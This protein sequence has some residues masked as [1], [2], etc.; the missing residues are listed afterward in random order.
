[1]NNNWKSS[2]WKKYPIRQQPN[3]PNNTELQKVLEE[4]K[5][6]PSLVFAGEI[7]NLTESLKNLEKNNSF[8]IQAG[9]CAESF[10]NCN[11][12][13]IHNYL[14]VILQMAKIIQN[15][16][17]KNIIKIGRIAG[18][19]SKPRSVDFETVA[20][21]VYEVYRGDNVNGVE[22]DQNIRKPN[23]TN[24]IKGY[25]YSAATLNL[26]RAFT[27]GGY[28][29][30]KYN[31]DWIKHPFEMEANQFLSD[32][33]LSSSR[34]SS[35][36]SN[37]YNDFFISHEALILDYEQAFTREDSIFGDFF[38][39]SAHTL[40]IGDR[41]RF[42]NSAHIEYVKG[43]NN[44]IGIKIGPNYDLND[45]ISILKE[46]NPLNELGRIMFIIRFGKDNINN[47][48]KLIT[49]VEKHK[50]NVIWMSDPMHGNTKTY[51]GIKYR[52]FND[53]LEEFL[54]FLKICKQ[55]TI[56]PGGVHL[57]ITGEKVTECIGGSEGI[58]LDDLHKNYQSKVDPQ[59]NA[60]QATEFAALISQFI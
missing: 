52:D 2:S 20:D 50:L 57:E 29:D 26:I 49:Q 58:Q 14:R 3:W 44:P 11:G 59:L 6:L 16:S 41:T 15:K 55:E 9:N 31:F 18:Q 34:K 30:L 10:S 40:W 8:I 28:T 12:P 60:L 4:L 37:R 1:M 47:L 25:F 24:L 39:T 35:I 46:I 56:Y 38:N 33:M 13:K 22:L 45:L 5:M 7:R 53:V 48:S 21:V 17:G 23:P 54:S 51:K 36:T 32:S 42:L 27:Q 43:I 19:Y